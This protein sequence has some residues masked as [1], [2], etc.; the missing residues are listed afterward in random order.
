MKNFF[1]VLFLI[2]FITAQGQ[3]TFGTISG[4]VSDTSGT[5]LP[6]ANVLIEGMKRGVLTDDNGV[7][8]IKNIPNGKYN[9]VVSFIGYAS[10][11]KKAEIQVHEK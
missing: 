3:E 6:F 4:T 9:I 10:K 7:Y 8:T 2:F 11:S 1:K 5:P